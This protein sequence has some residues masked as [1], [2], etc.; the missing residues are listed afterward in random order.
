MRYSIFLPTGFAQE[1]AGFSDPMVAFARVVELAKMADDA[2]YHALLAPDHL[3]TVRPSNHLVFEAWTLI[4]ALARETTNVRVGHLVT[5]NGYRNP[6][7]QAKMASTVDVLSGGRLEFGI[8]A[9]WLEPDHVQ[10][11]Y[12]YGTTGERLRRLEEALQVIRALWTEQKAEFAGQYYRVQGAVNEP[13]GVQR[14]HIPLMI[15]GSGEKRTLRLVAQ[16]GDACNIMDSAEVAKH[17]FAVLRD[18]CEDVGRDYGTIRRT[19]TTPCI[20]R[21]TDADARALIPLASK[22]V[23]PGDVGAYGLVGTLDTVKRRIAEF[24]EAGVQELVVY[25][26]DPTSVTQVAEFARL[27]V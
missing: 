26:E 25:F 11:G 3:T 2:G 6:A 18:H 10:Y 8:G 15:A 24:E 9:G 4:T 19:V 5:A 13:K 7:L 14:P 12:D 1:F 17:K 27:F 20:I 23:F 21:D 22:F 16:Y